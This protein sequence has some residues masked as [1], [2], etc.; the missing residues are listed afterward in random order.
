MSKIGKKVEKK[1]KGKYQKKNEK[2]GLNELD[3]ELRLKPT[4]NQ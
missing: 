2:S 1:K 3:S 4:D